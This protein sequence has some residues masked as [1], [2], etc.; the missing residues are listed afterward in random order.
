MKNL[1][2]IKY[3]R[4]AIVTAIAI[5][6]L[7]SCENYLNYQPKGQRIPTELADYEPMLR[8]EYG[9]LRFDCLQA[10]HLLNDQMCTQSSL[11]YYPYYKANYN[12]E[13]ETDRCYYNNSDETTYYAAYGG[14]ST[15]N[16]ILEKV[17]LTTATDKEKQ[18]VM[19]YAKVL[20]AM[21]YYLVTNYYAAAY[22][23][24]TAATDRAVP[25]ITSA[26]VNAPYTQ[27]TVKEIYDHM[28][29]DLT[30]ALPYLPDFGTTI[31]HQGKGAALA[32]LARIHLTMM[33]YD[34]ALDYANQALAIND[35]LYD[36]NEF[37]QQ[38]KEMIDNRE[39]YTAVQSPMSY[40]YVEN[41][42]FAHGS[43]SNSS[44]IKNM[45]IPRGDMFEDGDA[46]FYCNWKPR[47]VGADSY[48]YGCTQGLINY[49]GL[50]TVE[51]YLI[52]A[53]CLARKNDIT[54]AMAALNAVRKTR[55]FT[56]S[57]QPV[58]AK[59]VTEALTLIRQRKDNEMLF[60]IV[61]FADARRYNTENTY[62]AT[63]TFQKTVD[64][65]MK[66]LSP[67]SHLW[68]LPFPL[69]AIENHGNGSITQN[70]SR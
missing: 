70:V 13:E 20:R 18:E 38:N 16:L 64:G 47:T 30:E 17:P 46:Y 68:T 51:Q 49:N 5:S 56:E 41:Y 4:T 67:T 39:S 33:D 21:H 54:G 58:G 10:A 45:P 50:R 48:H 3:I 43:S 1:N 61:P 28:I 14:I 19:A 35:K 24:S 31:L 53:E 60:T 36:W 59:D 40:K 2:F 7:S 29:S 9:N 25:Y 66:T 42:S 44:R 11:S 63:R 23:P 26:E 69:G 52:K 32:M 55:I 8:Y 37:Y 62:I 27:V 22:N 15:C 34:K 65:A 57:Y 12:W 6:A